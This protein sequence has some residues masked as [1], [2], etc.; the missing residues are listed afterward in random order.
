MCVYICIIHVW[1]DAPEFRGFWRTK[2]PKC[3]TSYFCFPLSASRHVCV[4]LCVCV[5]ASHAANA[6]FWC[7]KRH[8]F[9]RLAFDWRTHGQK[10]IL[11][12]ILSYYNSV[13]VPAAFLMS[14]R[15][16]FKNT[17][18]KRIALKINFWNLTHS[19]NMKFLPSSVI[20]CFYNPLYSIE[21][22]GPGSK[23]SRHS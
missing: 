18:Q 22:L 1:G 21:L 17:F 11:N 7:F 10:L 4:C 16:T 8:V 23:A 9:D 2:I 6:C 15:S 14:K 19:P 3:W 20:L 5:C 13:V 12:F